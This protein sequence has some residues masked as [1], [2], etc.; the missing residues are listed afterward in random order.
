MVASL[1]ARQEQVPLC[2]GASAWLTSS[3]P[4][5]HIDMFARCGNCPGSRR[6]ERTRDKRIKFSHQ[7]RRCSRFRWCN[8]WQKPPWNLSFKKV[9]MAPNDS[10]VLRMIRNSSSSIEILS[11]IGKSLVERCREFHAHEQAPTGVSIKRGLDV[12]DDEGIP[13][14]KSFHFGDIVDTANVPSSR[15]PS[16]AD[17]DLMGHPN[18]LHLNWEC[19]VR[20]R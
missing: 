15:R 20:L 10:R 3:T 7:E 12:D 14:S 4:P 6:E 11:E 18:M 9:L 17:H 19:V 8:I 2:S 5:D 1:K 13:D 16:T